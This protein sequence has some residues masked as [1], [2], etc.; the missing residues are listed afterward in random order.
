[1]KRW[2]LK[3]QMQSLHV[4]LEADTD[5]TPKS[6]VV[7]VASA[8]G[9]AVVAVAFAGG[10]HCHCDV[11]ASVHVAFQGSADTVAG[12][13]KTAAPDEPADHS[14]QKT[15][16]AVVQSQKVGKACWCAAGV[17]PSLEVIMG[18][19]AEAVGNPQG[20]AWDD[21]GEATLAGLA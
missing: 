15:H 3:D 5:Q 21:A 11:A 2:A 7:E 19:E 16:Y 13:G 12:V 1:V 10:G 9:L 8:A 4:G 18:T 17:E 20:A 14:V 6:A